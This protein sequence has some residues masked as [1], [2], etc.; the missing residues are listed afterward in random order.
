MVLL[1]KEL[2]KTAE[3]CLCTVWS[4]VHVDLCERAWPHIPS[5]KISAQYLGDITSDTCDAVNQIFEDSGG[6]PRIRRGPPSR[7]NLRVTIVDSANAKIAAAAAGLGE[8]DMYKG[9]SAKLVQMANL[10]AEI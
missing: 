4:T 6:P 9:M 3:P 5:G 8:A 7:R 1:S 2:W 10:L